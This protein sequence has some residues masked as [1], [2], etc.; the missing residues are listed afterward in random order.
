M[1]KLDG[2]WRIAHAHLV[3]QIRLEVLGS[4]VKVGSV[5]FYFFEAWGQTRLEYVSASALLPR[6]IFK[7]KTADDE[8]AGA[9]PCIQW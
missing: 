5:F 8:Q 7:Q 4:I 1:R 2:E 3:L 9:V 6:Q